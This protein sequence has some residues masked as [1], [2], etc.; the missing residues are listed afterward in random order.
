MAKWK[1]LKD[2]SILSTAYPRLDGMDKVTGRAQYTSDVRPAGMLYGRLLTSPYPAAKVVD[3]DVSRAAKLAGVHVILTNLLE[4]KAVRYAGQPVAAVAADTPEIAADAVD[5]IRVKYEKLPFAADLDSA[6]QEGAP[7]VFSDRE[8]IV[9]ARRPTQKGDV[10]AG[11]AAADVVVEA[12]FR[13]QVQTHSCLETHGSM[14][15]W[16]GE[17]LY[18][19]DSTQGVHSVR[20]GLAKNL[21]ISPAQVHVICEHMGG[22]FGSKLQP[23]FYTAHAARLAKKAGRPVQ[24]MLTRKQDFLSAGNRPDSLQKLKLGAKKDGS[25]VAFSGT[26]WGTAGIGRGAR[27]RQPFIYEIPNVYAEHHDV[28]TNAGAARAFRAPGCPQASFAMEQLLDEVAEKLNMDPLDLRLK[29]ET[30]ATRR[31]EWKIGAEKIGWQ[32]RR[33]TPGS[34]SGPVKR[35]LGLGASIWWPGGRGTRATMTVFPDG[36]VEVR[37]GTQDIGTGTRT[38]VAA[39]AAEELGIGLEMIRPLIGQSDFPYS[40]GSGGSTTAPSVA[41]AIKNTSEKAKAKLAEIASGFFGA[42]PEDIIFE[43]GRV[44]MDKSRKKSMSW[45]ELCQ[46][47]ET[48][49]IT[50]HGEWVEGLS[51]A[52]VAGCQFAEVAVDTET[53][54]IRVEKVVAVADCGLVLDRLTTESQVNGAV[55]Q[56]VSYALYENRLMDPITGTMINA[57]FENYKIA[58]ALEVPE[59]EVVLFDE[60]ERGVIGIGEPPT[61]PTSAAIANAVYNAIGVRLRS[62][63]MTPDRVLDALYAQ[64][65]TRKED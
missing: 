7:R 19:Y 55:I 6:M 5:L 38:I 10:D 20:E 53:G 2:M 29:N 52:G 9:A 4:G 43:N 49:P 3:I 45:Q 27:V 48:Q 51:S 26:T 33:K 28:Y 24:L 57:D 60:P 40:G 18:V 56:G 59:I 13:T 34:D 36:K 15:E 35:G 32:R 65:V 22:G 41:P 14:V 11:F 37:C 12:T 44:Y 23:G 63:P 17:D 54:A 8:N 31:K 42:S 61:I 25:L 30:N 62:L 1:S 64:P 39:I 50:V 46:L 16:K 47:L 58:G 21:G